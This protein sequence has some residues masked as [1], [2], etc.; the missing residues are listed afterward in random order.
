MI[1]TKSKLGSLQNLLASL[2]GLK[3]S[4]SFS[5]TALDIIFKVTLLGSGKKFKGHVVKYVSY[6]TTKDYQVLY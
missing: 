5:D 2:S 4:H 6:W 3:A 1:V